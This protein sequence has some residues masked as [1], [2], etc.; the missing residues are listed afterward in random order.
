[1]VRGLNYYSNFHLSMPRL[2]DRPG[3]LS[4]SHDRDCAYKVMIGCRNPASREV[5]HYMTSA[6]SFAHGHIG[7][8]RFFLCLGD[9]RGQ[10]FTS[11]QYWVRAGR[12]HW[13][14]SW[15][16]SNRRGKRQLGVPER[17]LTM[18]LEQ[19]WNDS[20]DQYG[21]EPVMPKSEPQPLQWFA[22][23]DNRTRARYAPQSSSH[24]ND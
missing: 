9:L 15:P 10:R 11:G 1:M 4:S 16:P 20:Q 12:S 13:A 3:E 14:R 23:L 5:F 8:N 19:L 17:V 2:V 22:Q 21:Q 18:R 7:L 24:R 6:R